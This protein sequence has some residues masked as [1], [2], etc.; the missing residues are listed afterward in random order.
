[1]ILY[2]LLNGKD[3]KK[4]RTGIAHDSAIHLR[5]LKERGSGMV[6]LGRRKEGKGWRDRKTELCE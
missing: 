3:T 2:W 4:N 5:I 6:L 1:M